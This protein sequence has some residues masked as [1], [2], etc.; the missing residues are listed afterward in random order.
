MQQYD[1]AMHRM[2][3]L[4]GHSRKAARSRR[5]ARH[6]SEMVS[7]KAAIRR[8]NHRPRRRPHV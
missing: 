7:H 8:M 1:K 3:R 2:M 5:A 6:L 4:L